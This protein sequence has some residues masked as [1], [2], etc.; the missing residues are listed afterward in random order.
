[1]DL[2]IAH[3]YQ[4]WY[5]T[6]YPELSGFGLWLRG[7]E[8]NTLAPSEF[9]NRPFRVLFARLSTYQDVAVSAT[10]PLLYQTARAI[11]GVFP[12]LA[13]LPPAP[14]AAIF[15]R[16]KVPWLLATGSKI[17]PANFD[18]IGFSNSILQEIINVPIMLRKSRLPLRKSERLKNASLPLIILGGANALATSALYGPDP[19]VD[20][21]FA[22]EDVGLITQLLSICRDGKA[23]GWSKT[24][25]L[26]ELE[27]LPGFFQPDRPKTCAKYHSQQLSPASQLRAAPLLYGEEAMATGH[28]QISEGCAYSCS[29]CLESWGRKPYR[30]VSAENAIEQ[31]LAMKGGMAIESIELASFNFN[32]HS[33]IYRLLWELAEIFPTIRLKSQ[34]FDQLARQPEMLEWLQAVG[35]T[36]LTCGLEGISQRL[37]RYLHKDLAP[38]ELQQSLN[39]ILRAP[40]R[41]L[42]VFLIATGLEQ[43][44]DFDEFGEL[45]RTIRDLLARLGRQPRLI[46]SVTPLIRFPWTPLEFEDA[47]EMPLCQ[48]VMT[49]IALLVQ[50][51]GFECRQAADSEEYWLCQVLARADD[52]RIMAALDSAIKESGFVYYR[53]IPARFGQRF[54]QQLARLNLNP[55]E[56]L[57]G[58]RPDSPPPLWAN[59]GSGLPREMLQKRHERISRFAPELPEPLAEKSPSGQAAESTGLSE[60]SVGRGFKPSPSRPKPANIADFRARIQRMREESA[61][62]TFWLNVSSAAR[63]LPRIYPGLALARA[64]MRARPDLVRP[65]RGYRRSFWGGAEHTPVWLT[66]YD[67]ITLA[68]DQQSLPRIRELLGQADFLAQANAQLAGFGQLLGAGQPEIMARTS[69]RVWSPY[70]LDEQNYMA[71]EYLKYRRE[72]GP[73]G[74]YHYHFTKDSLKRQIILAMTAFPGEVGQSRLRLIVGHKFDSATFARRAFR[75]PSP[76]HWVTIA[77]EVGPIEGSD[78]HC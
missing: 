54:R 61:D 30:E 13:Y 20:G 66:G 71:K 31:A 75:L 77:L 73:D 47:V 43:A 76:R 18:C 1:V 50:Q 72:R 38:A 63:G 16:D 46:F 39:V 58:G 42:K 5:E 7:G 40:I 53:D 68:W 8:V 28:L 45:L 29:F 24:E 14:D 60:N 49:K 44:A 59:I 78:E 41:E 27:R 57:K 15:D 74:N 32:M 34:R 9:A 35:K 65:Y 12:D 52:P 4:A 23:R 69:I 26:T 67:L 10:H 48:A 11:E 6:T 56:L 3:S 62:I 36:S 17:D 21:I 55:S 51:H 64:I 33:D 22:G 2:V 70:P 19:L 37:R 25:I